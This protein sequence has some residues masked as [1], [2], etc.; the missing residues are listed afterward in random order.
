[1]APAVNAQQTPLVSGVPLRVD[2]SQPPP[3]P[4]PPP[5]PP[6]LPLTP[7]PPMAYSSL[8]PSQTF[9]S[10]ALSP[11]LSPSQTPPNVLQSNAV[12]TPLVKSVLLKQCVAG[13]EA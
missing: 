13:A 8:T 7:T 5:P 12:N 4:S 6:P 11:A 10:Q 1:M 2:A 9:K 3:L